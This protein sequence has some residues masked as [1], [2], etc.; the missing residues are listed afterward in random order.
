MSSA[1]VGTILTPT[2]RRRE[3]K[4]RASA[5]LLWHKVRIGQAPATVTSLRWILRT[6]QAHHSRDPLFLNRVRLALHSVKMASSRQSWS[7]G[8]EANQG[9]YCY[10]CKRMNKKLAEFCQSCGTHWEMAAETWDGAGHQ[11]PRRSQSARKRRQG[12][13]S[14]G[15]GSKD[16]GKDKGKEQNR[17]KGKD[18]PAEQPFGPLPTPFHYTPTTMVPSAQ[19]RQAALASTASQE[20]I[21]ALKK[22][23]ADS[24]MP[25]DIKDIVEK[26]ES[27]G[28]RQTTKELHAATTQLGRAQKAL[29]EAQQQR[30]SHRTAWLAHLTESMKLWEGQLEEFKKRQ[31]ALREA[32]QKAAQDISSARSTIQQ[33]NQNSS[34]T[35]ASEMVDPFQEEPV[36][37]TADNEEANLRAKLQQTLAQCASVVGV[38]STAV[39]IHSDGE[40]EKRA[41]RARSEEGRDANMQKAS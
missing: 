23:Y 38:T 25:Q 34:G 35:S 11:T 12:A 27:S 30:Q 14:D 19:N 20:L 39:E 18:G 2:Q 32:E 37:T 31:M 21:S 41:K 33:L 6:L 13:K 26:H 16:K 28:S 8:R 10:H 17:Q 7:G 5:R 9:W 15:K 36:E 4:Q 29:K 40:E 24:T 3:R 1:L 22:A